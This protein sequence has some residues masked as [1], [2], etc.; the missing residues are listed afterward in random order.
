MF[1]YN[2]S[3][4]NI[5]NWIKLVVK[6]QLSLITYKN[7]DFFLYTNLSKFDTLI[8][9]KYINGLVDIVQ[10]RIKNTLPEKLKLCLID[11][12]VIVFTFLDYLKFIKQFISLEKATNNLQNE[13]INLDDVCAY[14][15]LLINE[16]PDLEDQLEKSA[17]I[18]YNFIFKEAI[19]KILYRQEATL[20]SNE[21]QK[22]EL[23]IVEQS[24]QLIVN[25]E[26]M[27]IKE[28]I[29]KKYMDINIILSTLNAV[30][31]LF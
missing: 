2:T 12:Q 26:P 5:I 7:S 3:V 25:E 23:F 19:I 28:C 1:N 18:I 4:L 31:Y 16:Y 13:S 15:D 6:Y 9:S 21:K 30:E 20:I 8:V 27:T 14:F 17:S 24:E 11:R 29:A 10:K 22:V